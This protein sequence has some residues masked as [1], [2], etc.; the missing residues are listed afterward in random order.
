MRI[1]GKN[2]D[3]GESLQTAIE[4]KINNLVEKYVE[5][6]QDAS[7]TVNKDHRLFNIEIVLSVIKGFWIR[8]SGVSDDPYKALDSAIGKLEIVIKKHRN[9]LLDASRRTRWV[10]AGYAAVDRTL[11]HAPEKDPADEKLIIAEQEK[12]VLLLNVSEAVAKLELGDL[13]V[14]LFK[15]SDNMH[16]NVVYKR[17]DGHIGWIDYHDK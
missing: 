3:I 11:D 2:I 9:K 5:N 6:V 8:G 4:L 7:V 1:Y 16:I 15:N 13:P 10:E 14:V 12:Y 17:P